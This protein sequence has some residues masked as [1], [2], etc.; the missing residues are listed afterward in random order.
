MVPLPAAPVLML[1]GGLAHSL[2]SL[3][4]LPW[5]VE[6][7]MGSLSPK[8]GTESMLSMHAPPDC[9][10]HTHLATS[11]ISSE[12]QNQCVPNLTHDFPHL[13]M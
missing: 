12:N 6:H 4:V 1:L 10:P 8:D 13:F 9:G 7:H 11:L 5:D 3:H 2:L